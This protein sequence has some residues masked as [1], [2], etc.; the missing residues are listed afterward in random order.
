MSS[1]GVTFGCGVLRVFIEAEEKQGAGQVDPDF[2]GTVRFQ[3]ES[4]VL[5]SEDNV[6]SGGR[7]SNNSIGEEA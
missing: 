7:R 2:S 3:S 4:S 6:K 5:L 1:V